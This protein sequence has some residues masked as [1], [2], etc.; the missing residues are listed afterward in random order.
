[1][2]GLKL[3]KYLNTLAT[4]NNRLSNRSYP[5]RVPQ[6]ELKNFPR[7]IITVLGG[8]PEYSLSGPIP[9]LAKTI[10]VD[11]DALTRYEANEI[12]LLVKDAI[13][14]SSANPGDQTWDDVTVK[15][16]TVENEREQTFPP[17]DGS[18]QWTFR[19]SFDYRVTYVR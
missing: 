4:I 6:A 11:V 9:D 3:G 17:G 2:I 15:S 8:S 16:C 12:A 10:Q 18:D 13:E 1:M 7:A 19:R 5:D 14:F